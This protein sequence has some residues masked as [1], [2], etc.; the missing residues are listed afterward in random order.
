MA[1][2]PEETR[3]LSRLRRRAARLDCRIVSSRWRLD[4][5]D[6][7]GGFMIVNDRNLV[8]AGDRYDLSLEAVAEWIADEER[9]AA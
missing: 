7:H 1:R 8:V 3:E 9:E 6:N 5:I 4:T 2:T